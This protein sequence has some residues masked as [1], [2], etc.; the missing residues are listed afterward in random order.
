MPVCMNDI[1][2][3]LNQSV[4]CHTQPCSLNGVYQ[5]PIPLESTFYGIS[6]Y[7]YSVYDV[8]NLKGYYD[9]EKVFKAAKVNQLLLNLSLSLIQ[10]LAKFGLI[11]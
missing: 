2:P 8:L 9:H 10:V 1:K 7:W 3:L 11:T 6:E 5:P 4:T